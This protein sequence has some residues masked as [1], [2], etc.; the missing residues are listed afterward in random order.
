[1]ISL[2]H[3]FCFLVILTSALTTKA[4]SPRIDRSAWTRI[5]EA[6]IQ[7]NPTDRQFVPDRYLTY[8]LDFEYLQAQLQNVPSDQD[9]RNG[10]A[11]PVVVE[12][13]NPDGTFSKYR[14]WDFEVFHPDLQ[15]KY[16]DIRSYCGTSDAMG[17]VFFD[18]S[19]K[20]FHSMTRFTPQGQVWIDPYSKADNDHYVVY[21]RDDYSLKNEA[22]RMICH[23]DDEHDTPGHGSHF[24]DPNTAARMPN[25]L[26]GTR[27]EYRLALACTGEYGTFHG[28]TTASIL[29]AMNTS[30]TR[31]NGVF[32]PEMGV[33]MNIIANNNLIVYT[34]GATDPFSTNTDA[35]VLLD[36]NQ[37]N[38]DLVIGNANYD[39]GHIFSTGAGGVAYL[40]AVCWNP[41]KAGGVTGRGN[42]VGDPFNIDYV[43]H[44]IGHQFGGPHT[45]ASS[46]T[47][48]CN[49][50]GSASD[51]FEPGSGTTIMAYAG[52][53]GNQNVQSNSDA[54]F[55]AG[56][57]EDMTTEILTWH[58]GCPTLIADPNSAPEATI[59]ITSFAIPRSTP[60]VLTGSGTDPDG[61]PMFYCWEQYDAALQATAGASN[62]NG[63]LFRSRL[64]VSVPFR[65]FPRLQDVVSNATP[66][67]EFLPSV[68]RSMTFRL[69]VRDNQAL[70]AG[71]VNIEGCTDEADITV[72]VANVG[73]FAL[74]APNG[75]V[76]L[77]GNAAYTV[78]WNVSGTTANGINSAN[79]DILY[80]TNT[81]DPASWIMLLAN[82]PNDGTQSVTM[83][84]ITSSSF[85][86]IVRSASTNGI[87]FYDISNN[88]NSISISL[89]VELTSFDVEMSPAPNITRNSTTP[90]R[91]AQ[92]KW[93]TANEVNNKGFSIER[94]T[95]HT[96]FFQTIGWVDATTDL[97]AINRYEWAD[98]NI[99]AGHTYYYRLAQTDMDGT[100]TYSDIR[101]I[102]WESTA[103]VLQIAPNPASNFIQLSAEGSDL[104]EVFDVAV[105]NT[106]GQVIEQ[107]S[108]PLNNALST[109]DWPAGVYHIR[110]V[111]ANRI[112]TG[113]VVRM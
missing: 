51:A 70:P 9:I 97:Q 92:L 53:C 30:M 17:Y 13:P 99:R 83:P 31:V 85:R 41:F 108:M 104:D 32:M 25:A 12:F 77:T 10:D 82:T 65:F 6:Q 44:E 28:G 88:N 55:H 113:V 1:M 5:S 23:V 107:H 29:A 93:T 84:N 49:G 80:S 14:I 40:G 33:K 74:T 26:C 19:P 36:E 11:E 61:N 105:I 109:R 71:N 39:V 42:P 110:A 15:A 96:R 52:I 47:G 3:F 103:S 8:E 63:P 21:Y 94:S 58:N 59:P 35:G 75:G 90:S 16:P 22:D 64:P 56:S 87:F 43:A 38:T 24:N 7:V 20:G 98:P 78:T 62:A 81:S 72:T 76:S 91:V 37:T 60:F 54:Y 68:A 66:N 18:I 86:I 73:P 46:S 27:R 45:F 89:P 112:W 100:I 50:N 67:F 69:T 101:S 95:D 106:Q 111:A 102:Q 79:V 2:K 34:N 48:S 4:Q 57:L